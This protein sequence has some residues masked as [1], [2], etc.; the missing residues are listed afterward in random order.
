M[1]YGAAETFILDF[2]RKH[3][4]ENLFYHN[5][6]HTLDVIDASVRYCEMEKVDAGTIVV[7]KTAALL[8]DTGFVEQYDNNEPNGAAIAEKY[9][10]DFDY[11]NEQIA[12][13]RTLILATASPR[14]PITLLEKIICDADLDY[15]GRTDF[16]S[17]SQALRNEWAA[18]GRAIRLNDWYKQQKTFLESH[19]FY[20]ASAIKLRGT[21]K[22]ANLDEVIEL[23]E[24]IT[25]KPDGTHKFTGKSIALTED[26]KPIQEILSNTALFKH[27][28]RSVLEHLAMTVE[29]IHLQPEESLFL[30]GD[31]GESMYIII[32]GK[33][34]IHDGDIQLA[35]LGPGDHV[36]EFSLIDNSPRTASVSA[37]TEA[38][39][40]RLR[41]QEFTNLLRIH[42]SMN[43]MLMKEL[44]NR[45]RN[46]NDSVVA[47]FKSREAKLT[48]LVDLRTRQILEEKKNVEQ[49][50]RE[51]EAAMIELQEAQRLL[52]HQEKMASLG[53]LTTGIAHELL[54]P[55]NFVNNFSSLSIDLLEELLEL[56]S[57]EEANDLC[58]D[59]ID[60]IKRISQHGQR[61]GEIVRSMAEHSSAFGK[62]KHAVDIHALIADALAFS[63]QSWQSEHP[64]EPIDFNTDLAAA[65][66]QTIAVHS[67]LF[68]VITNLLRN[69]VSAIL[70][71]SA[72]EQEQ[73]GNILITSRNDE[74]TIII[75]INDNGVGIPETIREKIFNPF[76]TTRPTGKGVGLGL[77]ISH[78]IVTAF[79]GNLED[80]PVSKG[81][82]MR[83]TLPVSNS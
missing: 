31:I 13:I 10:P 67:D 22:K 42:P 36:G 58:K 51:L 65:N 6:A 47:E 20:T 7:M 2:L 37:A 82:M 15:L 77:S 52:I 23:L 78:Q 33:L 43:R 45:L 79:G 27:A 26:R 34:K 80:V 68:R 49:K 70:E 57:D 72:N 24:D 74:N 32:S 59:I 16:F 54:N 83:L 60:N 28:E 29:E 46:Q 30:K 39:I 44:I 11:N 63:K 19:V 5:I 61:A 3:L 62:E 73:P 12:L 76:F 8:H 71:R 56:T 21:Q 40:L 17:V 75:E 9:L 14:N 41:E 1:N 48:E 38:V 4:P 50:S 64:N 66:H 35:V 53:Q 81:A 25:R 18:H 55:L 69:A